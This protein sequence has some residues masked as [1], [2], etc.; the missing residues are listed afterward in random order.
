MP[1]SYDRRTASGTPTLDTFGRK[2]RT[3]TLSPIRD[4]IQRESRSVAG[5]IEALIRS[6]GD[7]SVAA[8]QRIQAA[9]HSISMNSGIVLKDT[10]K[11]LDFFQPLVSRG[12]SEIS[13]LPESGP[14]DS[15]DKYEAQGLLDA[16]VEVRARRDTLATD[17]ERQTDDAALEQVAADVGTLY[18]AVD[19]LWLGYKSFLSTWKQRLKRSKV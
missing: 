11:L 4:D 15:R 7:L 8:V 3:P 14:L 5:S 2:D 18:K 12:A 16:I 19:A 9:R 10:G 6:K 17:M 1:Y 13:S